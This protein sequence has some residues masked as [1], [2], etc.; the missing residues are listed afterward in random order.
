MGTRT[1]LFPAA[2]DDDRAYATYLFLKD[3]VEWEEGVRSRRGFTRLAKALDTG[4]IPEVDALIVNCLKLLKDTYIIDGVY[5]NYY[6]NGTNFTPSHSHKDTV[7]MVISLGGT[8]TLTVGTKSFSLN[9]GDMIVFGSSSH[10]VPPEEA[11][12]GRISIATFMKKV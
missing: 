12:E 9:N 11:D 1:T 2:I 3:N 6:Q 5:L 10:G 4:D 8:R 7:Q